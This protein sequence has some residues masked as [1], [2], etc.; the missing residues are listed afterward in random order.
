MKDRQASSSW[1][2]AC[3]CIKIL[4][5]TLSYVAT[6]EDYLFNPLVYCINRVIDCKDVHELSK[7]VLSLTL[8]SH[9]YATCS[10]QPC[11]PVIVWSYSFVWYIVAGWVGNVWGGFYFHIIQ[12][13]KPSYDS[14]NLLSFPSIFFFFVYEGLQYAYY[15]I[16]RYTYNYIPLYWVGLWILWKC[17]ICMTFPRWEK[18]RMELYRTTVWHNPQGPISFISDKYWRGPIK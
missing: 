13:K 8:P 15:K 14:N 2:C 9:S 10:S 4:R 1:E 17:S 6:T 5:E 11:S 12:K 3:V 16:G 7:Q 18:L